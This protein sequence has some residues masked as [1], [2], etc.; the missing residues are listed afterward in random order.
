MARIRFA[1]RAVEGGQGAASHRSGEAAVL[2]FC[3]EILSQV[4]AMEAAARACADSELRARTGAYRARLREGETAQALLP[5]AFATVREAARRAIGLRHHDVQI[6]GGAALHRGMI[7]EVRT[8]EGKTLTATLPAYVA[9]L[10]GQ[11]VHVIT[12]NDYLATRDRNWMRPVYEFL[13]LT[14]GL[15]EPAPKA[16]VAVRRAQYAADVTYGPWAEFCYDFLRDNLVISPD[17]VSQRGLGVAIVDEADL[18]LIDEMCS[19]SMVSRRQPSRRTGMRPSRAPS[20]CYGLTLIS[21]RIM[22]PG[23]LA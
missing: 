6:M 8:G 18:V 15:L 20:R 3:L 2:E 23:R 9:A 12:A 21:Q 7:A 13:G 1:R 19:P 22:R 14:A 11:P 10:S 16:D 5:E 17:E 4:N